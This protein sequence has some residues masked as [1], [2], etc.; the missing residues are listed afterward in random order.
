MVL[1]LS[2]QRQIE[3]ELIFRQS[4]ERVA[5]TL[6]EVDA[7]HIEDGNP[8]L[9]LNDQIVL[10]FLCECSDE[11]CKVRIP[12]GLSKYKA[13]H[14]SRKAFLIVPDHDVQAIEKVVVER[15]NFAVVKKHE[16]VPEPNGTLNKTSIKNT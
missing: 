7:N 15:P 1:S 11:N 10:H 3:N 2:K 14:R 9:A 4:N 8:H 5:A 16:L 13:I 6:D 12:L